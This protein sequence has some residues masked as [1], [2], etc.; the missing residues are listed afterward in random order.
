MKNRLVFIELI[1]MLFL[2]GSVSI[3]AQKHSGLSANSSDG[4]NPTGIFNGQTTAGL[5]QDSNNSD[6]AWLMEIG[7]ASCR[8][9]V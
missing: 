3:N 5:W 2:L 4:Q 8:E 6:D 9:R 7:R 1:A